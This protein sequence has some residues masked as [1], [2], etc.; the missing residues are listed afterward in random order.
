MYLIN[1]DFYDL[2]ALFIF[3]RSKPERLSDYKSALNDIIDYTMTPQVRYVDHNNI[4]KIIRP[5]YNEIDEILSWLLVDNAY[6]TNVYIIKQEVVYS[7]IS[8]ILREMLDSC[9]DMS[10]SYLLCDATHNIPSVLIDEV[11]KRKIIRI[12]IKE[13]RK[14]Y[15]PQFLKDELKLL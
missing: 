2:Q 6:P 10:R 9:D 4:R 12:M 7:I 11:K 15:D 13:Y 1:Y 14:R 8:A 5:Y 3:F